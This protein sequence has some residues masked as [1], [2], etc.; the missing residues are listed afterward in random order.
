MH[1]KH[2]PPSTD[3][4]IFKRDSFLSENPAGEALIGSSVDNFYLEKI[5]KLHLNEL[6]DETYIGGATN[7]T[8]E[9]NSAKWS[10]SDAFRL[11]NPDL[12]QFGVLTPMIFGD[13]L[14]TGLT[15]N[16]INN[17]KWLITKNKI[18]KFIKDNTR[19]VKQIYDGEY[20]HSEVLF[21]EVVKYRAR[22]YPIPEQNTFEQNMFIPNVP[23]MDVLKYIDTQVSFDEKY[24]YQ[25]YAHTMVLGTEYE[26]IDVFR[27]HKSDGSTQWEKSAFGMTAG[28]WENEFHKFQ[29]QGGGGSIKTGG[30]SVYFFDYAYKPSVYLMRVPFYNTY[31]TTYDAVNENR[32]MN[33]K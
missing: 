32:L 3:V 8:H 33:R 26:P 2:S 12:P 7:V 19:S 18:L 21:Y 1:Y 13:T 31:V 17:I 28:L 22:P 20:A 15:S 16:F 5:V 23:G 24:Y 30:E 11:L 29:Q 10:A 9:E 27:G 6:L 14:K 25:I 4:A